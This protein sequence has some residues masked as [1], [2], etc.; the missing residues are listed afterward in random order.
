MSLR[1]MLSVYSIVLKNTSDLTA[2]SSFFLE[3][4]H[5]FE[6]TL[7]VCTSRYY[8]RGK[9]NAEVLPHDKDQYQE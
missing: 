7:H 2:G 3:K 6:K 1:G 8:T 4:F 5:Y 9:Q